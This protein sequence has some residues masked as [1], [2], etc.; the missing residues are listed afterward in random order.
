MRRWGL[1]IVL[2]L[3]LGLNLGLAGAL[4]VRTGWRPGKVLPPADRPLRQAGLLLA[5]RIGL[6]GVARE[7]FL[8]LHERLRKEAAREARA[9][10]ELRQRLREELSA[11]QSSRDLALELVDQIAAHQAALERLLVEHVFAVRGTL[12][13][14]Q[15]K[16][17]QRWLS[18]TLP[19][20]HRPL[21]RGEGPIPERPLRRWQ[22]APDVKEREGPNRGL[23][24]EGS[25]GSS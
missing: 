18:R 13:P 6:E 12:S 19:P 2:L 8:E 22:D 16:V 23:A 24:P 21:W 1:W 5:D 20:R 7:R 4:W 9:L 3:S 25:R 10:F 15:L 17:Y 11:E 14:S